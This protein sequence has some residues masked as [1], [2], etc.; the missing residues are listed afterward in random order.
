MEKNIL[1]KANLISVSHLF[2]THS[3]LFLFLLV[4]FLNLYSELGSLKF[5]E[6]TFICACIGKY[7]C[8]CAH[9]ENT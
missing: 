8:A 7:V 4:D 2:I 6:T 5:R 1:T 3:F 9:V